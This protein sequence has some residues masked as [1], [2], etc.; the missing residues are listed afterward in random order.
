M[1][2][3]LLTTLDTVRRRRPLW[4]RC[5]IVTRKAGKRARKKIV[6]QFV[7][8]G[9]FLRG[10]PIIRRGDAPRS[11]QLEPLRL[12][13]GQ[14][15]RVKTYADIQSTLVERGT[16]GMA[17]IPAVMNKYCGRIMRVQKSLDCFYDEVSMRLLKMRKSS[18]SVLL[19]GAGCD[20]SQIAGGGCDRNCLIFWREAWLQPLPPEEVPI[21]AEPSAAPSAAATDIRRISTSSDPV[22]DDAKNADR[23]RPGSLVRVKTREEILRTLDGRGVCGQVGFVAEHMQQFCGSVFVVEKCVERFYDEKDDFVSRMENT[24]ALAGV[25]CDGHQPDSKQVCNRGCA[26]F[27]KGEWLE[28]LPPGSMGPSC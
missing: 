5:G 19:E 14:W 15:V 16:G 23:I 11:G 25:Y 21:S 7:K 10:E 20:G 3:Q 17:Y 2:C 28:L 1:W 27:W 22:D 24:Y 13:P 8:L 9:K 4:I 26:L 6:R 18:P 12:Q